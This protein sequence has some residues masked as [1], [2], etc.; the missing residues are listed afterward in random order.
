MR[1]NSLGK[2]GLQLSQIGLG[3]MTWGRDTGE[4]EAHDH[5]Q[6]YVE[7]G[8][9]WLDTSSS[10]G[11]GLSETLVGQVL[12]AQGGSG[13]LI[14]T[15]NG[16]N[17]SGSCR[18]DRKTLRDEIGASLSR[19]GVERIDLWQISGPD[20]STPLGELAATLDL[21]LEGGYAHYVAL[22]NFPAWHLADLKSHMRY[23]SQLVA[24]SYEY[25]L[26]ARE[27]DADVLPALNHY[28]MGLL[29]WSPLGRGVLTGKYRTAIPADSRAASPHLGA[30]ARDRMGNAAQAVVEAVVAAANGLRVSPAEVAIAWLANQPA[31]SSFITG[32]RTLGQLQLTLG[33]LALELPE[34]VADALT[35]VSASPATYPSAAWYAD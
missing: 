33:A 17:S 23:P 7:A 24:G 11:D 3:T 30:F 22:S 13:V 12:R 20:P 15:R 10:F 29:A 18:L 27:I 34:V 28:D 6:L 4:Y 9:N 1:I 26:I 8:G 5:F 25:S 16:L 21:V 14:S 31:V 35:E 19:L 2:S 32:A